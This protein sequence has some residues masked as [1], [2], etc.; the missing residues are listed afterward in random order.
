MK[1]RGGQSHGTGTRALAHSDRHH[2]ASGRF[3]IAWNTSGTEK[4][5]ADLH[6]RSGVNVFRDTAAAFITI[7][8]LHEKILAAALK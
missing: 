4:K 8:N 7:V 5:I 2:L 3:G 1:S 6:D